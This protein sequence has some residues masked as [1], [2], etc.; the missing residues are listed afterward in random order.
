MS[1][2]SRSGGADESSFDYVI[3]GAGSAGCVLAARLSEEPGVTVCLI[4]AG[5]RDRSPYLHV[6]AGYIKNL[7]DPALTWPF[8]TEPG[9]YTAGRRQATTQGRVLGGSSAINGLVYNRGQRADYDNWAQ[10]G[11]RGWDYASVLPYFQ[12]NEQRVGGEDTYRGRAGPLTV[13]NTA[14]DHPLCRAFV[15]G[16]VSLGLPRNADYNGRQQY[17]VGP[18]QYT[19]SGRRRMSSA[20]AFLGPALRRPN[21]AVVTDAR[22]DRILF[23]GRRATGV[24]YSRA[25]QTQDVT[26]RREVIIAAGAI[27]TPKLLQISGVGPAWLLNELGV[28]V[29]H[30]LPGVGENLRDH[31]S[32][33]LSARVKGTITINDLSRGPRFAREVAR[34]VA[35]RPS[36]LSLSPVLMHAFCKSQPGLADSDLQMSFVPGSL[37]A[38]FV[39]M[40]DTVPGMSCGGYQQRPESVGYV[41][42]RSATATDAPSIQPNY[43]AKEG[44]RRA[45][46]AVMR[47][48]RALLGTAA[49]APYYDG[50]S[51]PGPALQHD[52]EL[53]DFARGA[54]STVYHLVGSARMGPD[55][56]PTAVLDQRL[57]V[58]GVAG[59][60]VV[61]AS[62]MPS[63]PSGNTNAPTL[64]IAERGADLILGRAPLPEARLDDEQDQ[65]KGDDHGDYATGT[66]RNGGRHVADDQAARA[67]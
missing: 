28:A 10:S 5:P 50:E 41:R 7:F 66:Y 40:L 53:L 13:T 31:Y 29:V 6:P 9:E 16:A 17:G 49:M 14:W 36:I 44:D 60:R 59:L 15:A 23:T 30:D 52:D 19:I 42:A 39:G 62:V 54:G 51:F 20:R 33:R 12:R 37:R 47:Q 11:L 22:A 58:R 45:I 27:N 64:M 18:F 65:I 8:Q 26:A 43:L 35:G 55:G 61:D 24:K 46:L 3:V 25:G 4:E 2:R 48:A 56:D 38:G 1:G 67:G 57:C 63:L 34:W 21:L 32:V